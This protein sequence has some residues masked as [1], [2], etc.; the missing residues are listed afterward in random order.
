MKDKFKNR[1]ITLGVLMIITI[2]SKVLGL[3]RETSLAYFFGTNSIVDTYVLATTIPCV[4]FGCLDA[5]AVAITPIY[6]KEKNN[7]EE[8]ANKLLSNIVSWVCVISIL[9]IILFEVC[10]KK[11]ISLFLIFNDS[12]V[13]IPTLTL[14][15]RI[16]LLT[17]FFNP[18][19]QIYLS[20]LRCKDKSIAA[21]IIELAISGFQ[22]LFIIIAGK[23]LN[24]LLLPIGYAVA[25]FSCMIFAYIISNNRLSFD[26]SK[27]EETKDIVK[28]IFPTFL[29]NTIAQINAFIDKLFA[30]SLASGS[31]AA[32]NYSNIIKNL[33]YAIFTAPLISIYYPKIS[34]YIAK[35]QKE[36]AK[37]MIT[38]IIVKLILFL[39]PIS[40]F[41]YI[42]SKNIIRIL[43]MRG[44]FDETSLT[45]TSL[46]FQMYLVGVFAICLR[47][48][49]LRCLYSLKS[50]KTVIYI[51]MINVILNV[52]LNTIFIK[53]F[54]YYGLAL[55][56]SLSNV[57]VLPIYF[58]KLNKEKMLDLKQ[59]SIS[60]IKTIVISAIISIILFVVKNN[61]SF[62]NNVLLEI[63]YIAIFFAIGTIMFVSIYF[64]KD[65]LLNIKK[66]GKIK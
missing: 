55:A 17:I 51:T 37:K 30:S 18:I 60:L 16:T 54:Q 33:Y 38:N 65:I 5:V 50:N 58:Y 12:T 61:I 15:F 53:K 52:I 48:V 28:L 19:A 46:A 31:I 3:M 41:S 44:N 24:T 47:E 39:I 27:K 49:F 56:T 21:Q 6:M 36:Q 25:H 4:I 62:P 35:K 7:S 45:M 29:G 2:I 40:I 10:S 63:I 64:R 34:E 32:L 8:K 57:I 66:K 13:D 11:F 9:L 43:F 42:F 20:Y 14:Y 26:I 1:N 59:I 22:I 23:T